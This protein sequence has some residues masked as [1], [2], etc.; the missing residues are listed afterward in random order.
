M[1]GA[2]CYG[3][4]VYLSIQLNTVNKAHTVHKHVVC[5][6]TGTFAINLSYSCT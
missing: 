3:C 4:T 6:A 5:L 1:L 2:K